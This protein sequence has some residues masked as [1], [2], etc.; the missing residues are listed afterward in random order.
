MER[1]AAEEIKVATADY[2]CAV[3]ADY[4]KRVQVIDFAAQQEFV[5]AHR[6]QLDVFRA[7]IA[8][9]RQADDN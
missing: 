3:E 4:D 7:A 6:D 9:A 8:N 5:D 1:L 2:H